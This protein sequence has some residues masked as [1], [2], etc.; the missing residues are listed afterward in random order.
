MVKWLSILFLKF[1]ILQIVRTQNF[2]TG[3]N[4]TV[5]GCSNRCSYKDSS[6]QCWNTS[7]L[8]FEKILLGQMTNYV[9]VQMNIDQWAR[10]H[11]KPYSEDFADAKKRSIKSMES[12]LHEGDILNKQTIETVVDALVDLAAQQSNHTMLTWMT[13]FQ[14]P[15]PCEH[16]YTVWRNL[17]VLFFIKGLGIRISDLIFFLQKRFIL[18]TILNVCLFICVLP[19]VRRMHGGESSEPLIHNN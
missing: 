7:L 11:K 3:D 19:L 10:R 17:L 15:I 13:H 4:S 1:C 16:R 5:R 18:S 2:E 12:M 9:A 8:F 6:L 14:C